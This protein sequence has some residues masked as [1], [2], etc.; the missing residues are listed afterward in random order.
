MQFIDR[1]SPN[2][3]DRS[4]PVTMVVLHYTG[5]QDAASAIARLADPEAKV[6]CHYLVAEDGTVVRMVDEARRAWHAGRSHWRGVTDINSASVG[7][8]IV[9]PGHEWGYVPFPDEQIDAVIR[10]V[11]D[12]KQ[13]HAITRGNVV[14]HSDIAPAR[15]Q[16]P[17]ELFPW[18]K[19]ARLRLALPRPTKNLMDP[20]WADS[21]FLLALERFGYDVSD[22]A[23]A[24]TAFQRRFR[25][26]MVDGVIDAECRCLLLA[27]L[28]P[29]PQGD[30]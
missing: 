4:L 1:P 2:F 17:G 21:G 25:P 10:L 29:K 5:M 27:L 15:K 11:A 16:D 14:G 8:E 28:L 6:S 30:D 26:E 7:I 23:A 24:V 19:L 9:N 3:D 12:I 18:G 20:G 22:P 13:R